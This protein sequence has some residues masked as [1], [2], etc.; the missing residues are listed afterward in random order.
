[1]SGKLLF[2][3][4]NAQ[5][6]EKFFKR[7]RYQAEEHKEIC[8]SKRTVE[9]ILE[10]MWQENLEWHRKNDERNYRDSLTLEQLYR[11]EH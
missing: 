11:L 3:V 1:M 6:K 5:E 4:D 2:V 9:E 8:R 10:S 7:F